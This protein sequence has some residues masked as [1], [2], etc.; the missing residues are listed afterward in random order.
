[1][2]N[3]ITALFCLVFLPFCFLLSFA[4]LGPEI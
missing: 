3:L 1:M 4:F 2:L